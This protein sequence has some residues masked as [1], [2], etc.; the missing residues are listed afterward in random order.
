MGQR[1]REGEPPIVEPTPEAATPAGLFS[2]A[3]LGSLVG[4]IVLAVGLS[5]FI[6]L[7]IIAPKVE[8]AQITKEEY[9]RTGMAIQET[10]ARMT[11]YPL[12]PIIVNLAGTNAERYLKVTLSFKYEQTDDAGGDQ[13][14]RELNARRGEIRN[15]L[16][17]ILSSK[18]LKDVDSAEGR[19][20][21]RREILDRINGMLISGRVSDV[22]YTEFVVQ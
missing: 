14:G 11:E 16:I 17:S 22:Y 4:A 8:E 5:V 21:I 6:V 15:Q 19:A 2:P 18:A 20:A 13:L 1:V 3:M 10:L 12:E 9:E 7:R